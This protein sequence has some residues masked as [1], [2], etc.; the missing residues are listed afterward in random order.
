MWPSASDK[1]GKSEKKQKMVGRLQMPKQ[2]SDYKEEVGKPGEGLL[3]SLANRQN[4]V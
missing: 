2:K 4:Q 1:I 3:Q